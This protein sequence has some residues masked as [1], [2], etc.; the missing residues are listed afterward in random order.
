MLFDF[1]GHLK[2]QM[3]K[4]LVTRNLTQTTKP[5]PSLVPR[6]RPPEKERAWYP[7]FVH[8]RNY[9]GQDEGGGAYD[10]GHGHVPML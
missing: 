1:N 7:L 5:S 10:V 6:P 4:V 2:F 8:A 3:G 9:L